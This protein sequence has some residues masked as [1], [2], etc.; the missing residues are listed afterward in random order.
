[1]IQKMKKV[2]LTGLLMAALWLSGASKSV[3]LPEATVNK[4]GLP[5]FKCG[6]TVEFTIRMPQLNGIEEKGLIRLTDASGK[7]IM[8]KE[9]NPVEKGV[10]KVSGTLDAPG[11]I[12]CYVHVKKNA[13]HVFQ[14]LVMTAAFEPEKIKAGQPRPKD[15]ISFWKRAKAKFDKEIPAD[16]KVEKLGRRGKGIGY[17]VSCANFGGT[18][19]YAF[20]TI[21]DTPGKY[22]AIVEV[23]PAGPGIWHPSFVK[24]EIR[25]VINVF[26][27]ELEKGK[28]NE[29][30]A[31][32]K[33]YY[34]WRGMNNRETYY[35]YKSILG[36]IRMLDY[37]T[38]RS[39]WDGRHLIMNGRSQ[40]G[41]FALILAGLYYKVSAVAAD[42]PALCDHNG[43]W[44]GWPVIVKVSKGAASEAAR[45]Y[46]VA[47][48]CD[49]IHCPVI[50][51]VGFIDSMCT[52]QSVYA[53]YNRLKTEKNIYIGVKTGH[54][55]GKKMEDF[56][57][58][59][60][61]WIESQKHK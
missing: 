4:N 51:G 10:Y 49:F 38:S 34:F 13:R 20:L 36:A 25:M 17:K 45:Y 6:E 27:Q 48:F 59:R 2:L 53:A 43:V 44:P 46:D 58:K 16:F 52:P 24:E 39:E 9:I 50:I 30:N 33:N 12:R 1:M 29:Y 31:N 37:L 56:Y 23:P 14:P 21:P 7:L 42:V 22:A 35:Y 18:R 5:I 32:G 3:I 26:D 8:S 47:N 19:T 11:F 60:T 15:F 57:E 55:W 61:K 40:G 54:G 28:Y 41:A